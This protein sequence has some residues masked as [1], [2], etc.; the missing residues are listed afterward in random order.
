MADSSA[1]LVKKPIRGILKKRVKLNDDEDKN[2]GVVGETGGGSNPS[3]GL[4]WDEHTIA[5]HDSLRGTRMKIEEPKT[6]Y[7]HNTISMAADGA[8]ELHSDHDDAPLPD[9]AHPHHILHHQHHLV[10]TL[11]ALEEQQSLGHRIRQPRH[12]VTAFSVEDQDEQHHQQHQH[13]HLRS[14]SE[15][16]SDEDS[17]PADPALALR[18]KSFALKRKT[19][20][21]EFSRVKRMRERNERALRGEKLSSSSDDSDDSE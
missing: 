6:P 4:S 14:D 16:D 3:V 17:A 8:E 5:L 11:N 9:H 13:V 15:D 20:Y 19:H 18:K 2:V 7:E 10:N 1:H 21:D 12:A